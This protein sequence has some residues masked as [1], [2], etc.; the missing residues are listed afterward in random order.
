MSRSSVL[1]SFVAGE[2]AFH[3]EMMPLSLLHPKK[4]AKRRTP[5]TSRIARRCVNPGAECPTW[6]VALDMSPDKLMV[7]NSDALG[8]Q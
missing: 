3:I 7:A 1:S 2:T 8:S 5:L 4:C 6:N